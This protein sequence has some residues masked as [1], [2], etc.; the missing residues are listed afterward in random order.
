MD[1]RVE[2]IVASIQQE[3]LARQSLAEVFE[4]M[5]KTE[6]TKLTNLVTQKATFSRLDCEELQKTVQESLERNRLER[7]ATLENLVAAQNRQH[8]N[9]EERLGDMDTHWKNMDHRC[10]MVMAE[11]R[12]TE[13]R[14]RKLFDEQVGSALRDVRREAQDWLGQERAAR[15]AKEKQFAD[16]G[17]Y[18]RAA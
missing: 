5:L 17:I 4:Q 3:S 15:E 7:D 8:A 18:W 2:H 14:Y 1:R 9:V 6:R 10:Q 13:T 16:L 12:D 11:S